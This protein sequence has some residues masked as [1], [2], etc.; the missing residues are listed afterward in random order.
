MNLNEEQ[1]KEIE[2]Y[3]GLMFTI[4]E[5]AI[6]MN[7][8]CSDLKKEVQNENGNVYLSFKKGRLL[9]EAKIRKSIFDLAEDGSSPAH[10]LSLDL[11]KKAKMD[12]IL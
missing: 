4:K 12:D 1:L 7:L 11:I 5:I 3:A 2:E 10:S 6:I 9:I 8:S